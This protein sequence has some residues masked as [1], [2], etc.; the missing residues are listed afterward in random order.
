MSTATKKS[1]H[2]EVHLFILWENA[3]GEEAK[4]LADIKQNFDVLRVFEVHWTKSLFAQNLSRFYGTQLP[5]GSRK[6][7][8]V[9]T[10]PF[11]A[12]IV[13]DKNPVYKTHTTSKGDKHV[14]TNLFTAKARHR[15]WTGGGHRIHATNTVKEA[16]H[17]ITL[18][19]GKNTS[20]FLQETKPSSSI[21]KWNK[22]VVGAHGWTSMAQLLYVLNNT[23]DYVVLR[24]FEPLPD[25]YYAKDHGDIDLLVTNYKDACLTTNSKPMYKAGHRVYNSVRIGKEAVYFDFRHFNDGYYDPSWEQDILE[26]RTLS[27]KGFYMPGGTDYFYS[28]LYHALI[29]KPSLGKD[30]AKRLVD[31]AKEHGIKL[32]AKSFESEEAAVVLARFLKERGYA[33]T[34]PDDKSVYFHMDNIKLGMTVGVKFI[35][36]KRVPIRN[37]FKS[38][39]F[40]IK[41]YVLKVRRVAKARYHKLKSRS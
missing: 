24:N 37:Y 33:F 31:V 34:Q 39:R 18:L 11:L 19:F 27:A 10:N 22:D 13:E 1:S 8:H 36:H 15:D 12:L 16:D 17:D 20:D 26:R 7:L 28:L 41:H 9:G 29:H 25:N 23:M 30:Y 6:E 32:T 3:R 21:Q 35:R 5:P 40:P 14:N 38:S 2:S 4:I